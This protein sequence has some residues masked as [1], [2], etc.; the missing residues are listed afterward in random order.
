MLKI[1]FPILLLIICCTKDQNTTNNC[2]IT[3]IWCAYFNPISTMDCSYQYE[4]RSDGSFWLNGGKYAT[5]SITDCSTIK[6]CFIGINGP[7]DTYF[8]QAIKTLTTDSLVI[9]DG[10]A[11]NMEN[12]FVKIK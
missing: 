3:G 12:S 9:K 10:L 5:W 4:Y 11:Q 1:I 7:C 8:E 2:S 6:I